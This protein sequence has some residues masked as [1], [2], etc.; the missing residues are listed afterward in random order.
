MT[1]IYLYLCVFSFVCVT[2]RYKVRCKKDYDVCEL[3]F[4]YV[5]YKEL[6]AIYISFIM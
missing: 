4:G 3:M 5:R 6:K 1:I 2:N